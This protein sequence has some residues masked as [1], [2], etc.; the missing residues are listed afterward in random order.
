MDLKK[1]NTLYKQKFGD[2][3]FVPSCVKKDVA[4]CLNC[5][6]TEVKGQRLLSKPNIDEILEAQSVQSLKLGT[7]VDGEVDHSKINAGN[8]LVHRELSD[9]ESTIDAQN[10]EEDERRLTDSLSKSINSKGIQDV[11]EDMP[12]EVINFDTRPLHVSSTI[13]VD[14]D[15]ERSVD[16][17]NVDARPLH[18]SSTIKVDGEIERSVE[19]KDV[20]DN[21]TTIG[22]DRRAA[23]EVSYWRITTDVLSNMFLY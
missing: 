7:S 1:F 18:V 23:E 3:V 15:I 21:D 5:D 14:G 12:N 4:S 22:C 9:T 6:N 2:Y 20:K 10:A 8:T 11:K 16:A 19:A 17:G 13:K